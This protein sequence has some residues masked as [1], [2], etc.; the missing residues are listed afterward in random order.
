M[1]Q[2]SVLELG[3]ARPAGGLSIR[4]GTCGAPHA[5]DPRA[6]EGRGLHGRGDAH[7]RHI[8]GLGFAHPETLG[9]GCSDGH[10]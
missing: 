10:D 2:H 9:L 4:A 6:W 8:L 7:G 3:R 1:A 5:A